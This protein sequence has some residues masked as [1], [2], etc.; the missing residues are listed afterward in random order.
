MHEQ[1][2]YR[3]QAI[4][5]HIASQIDAGLYSEGDKL[6]S[7]R[8]L[9]AMHEVSL[10]T[11]SR[12]LVELETHGYAE[13]RPQ[14]G[15]Y[16]RVRKRRLSPDAPLP[17]S[18]ATQPAEAKVNKLI[19]EIF[20]ATSNAGLDRKI[21]SL[22]AAELDETLLPN[23]E[24]RSALNR[25]MTQKGPSWLAY[26]H[27]AGDYSLRQRIAHLM[28]Q[29]GVSLTPDDI[30]IT[31]GQSEA[32]GMAL[33]GLARA[34]DTIAV[35][36][37]CYFGTLQWIEALGLKAI[38]IS[39][40]PHKGIDIDE[41]ER[42]ANQIPL[43]AVAL[44]P[45]F[46]N[47]FGFAMPPER[48]TRLVELSMERRLP[49]IE[50]DVYGELH[51]GTV[52]RR[53]LKS[54]DQEG[55]SI[56]C[57]SF[58]K[59]LAPGFRIGWCVPGRH[60][61]AILSAPPGLIFGVSTL[62]QQALSEYLNGRAYARHLKLLRDLFASQRA[63]VRSLVLDA[64]PKGTRITDPEGGFVFWVEVPEPFDAL[65]F[66]QMALEHGISIAPGP[67][68]SASGRFRNAFRLSIGRVLTQ[69][70]KDGIL[71]LGGL[72]RTVSENGSQSM[73]S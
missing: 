28:G 44:N 49:I 21:L 17:T 6:P 72:A 22:G 29:R 7:I 13:A 45:T 53:P 2:C 9:M 8:S 25:A 34:G 59:T 70:V 18:S 1:T 19:S 63:K 10:A 68:F 46:H 40:D 15:F 31:T 56:Y 73:P 4:A 5:R 61:S 20:K 69:E 11:A 32:M 51:Q 12:A 62:L 14:S 24:L 54:F 26:C 3:Y 42:L 41:L 60:R 67:I 16:A 66:Y 39:T 23:K 52:P 33:R 43:A 65:A 47:P 37:P 64:F 71:C 30:V 58:S 36:S 50:D 57:S 35:E 48:M 27:P 55:W 38:E